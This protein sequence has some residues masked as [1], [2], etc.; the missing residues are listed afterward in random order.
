VLKSSAGAGSYNP[1]KLNATQKNLF[2]AITWDS[3]SSSLFSFL[4]DFVALLFFDFF[5]AWKWIHHYTNKKLN[6]FG[7]KCQQTLDLS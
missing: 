6:K 4:V 5:A 3:F 2:N 1:I 7:I